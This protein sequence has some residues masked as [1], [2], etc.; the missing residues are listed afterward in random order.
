MYPSLEQLSKLK[1]DK[2]RQLVV[3]FELDN[4]QLDSIK[5]SQ[6]PTAAT[7]QTAK[8]KNIDI[9]WKD[10]VKSLVSIGEYNLAECQGETRAVVQS[11][12]KYT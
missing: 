3:H 9:Q 8:V 5:K 10:I 11:I 7:L 6:H 1:C 4:D 2:W 12:Y